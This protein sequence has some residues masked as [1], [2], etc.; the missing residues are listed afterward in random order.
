M[1]ILLSILSAIL[2]SLFDV[3]RK[4]AVQNNSALKVVLIIILSQFVFFSFFLF[5]SEFKIN[6]SA[7]SYAGISLIILNVLSI[8]LFLLVLK[9]GKI[10][11]Y[12]PM[13]SFTP[14]FSAI[15][16]RLILNEELVFFQYIGMFFI[17][18]GSLILQSSQYT[19]QNNLSIIH[20][21]FRNKNLF[22][23]LIVALIW[24]LTPVL[25]KE[26]LKHTD[27]YF[28]GFLQASGMIIVFPLVLL[29]REHDITDLIKKPCF[30]F[31]LYL[32]VILGFLTAFLQLTALQLVFVAELE[33]LKRGI[34]IIL[35]LVFG[36]FIFKEEVNLK[37]ILSVLIIIC[38]VNFIIK[39]A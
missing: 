17:V 7:Y 15:Y 5:L 14:L 11:I 39:F 10:S 36:H 35:S 32:V 27:L 20:N 31:I 34:G 4:K 29:G 21:I 37:K 12:I 23:I 25:D 33:S 26:C 16:S 1:G 9:S 13:L 2:W 18:I 3:I 8:Y 19:Y 22:Y 28:H 24:S 38:G 6:F 30:D